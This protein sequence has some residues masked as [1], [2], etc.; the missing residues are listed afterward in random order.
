ML[1]IRCVV[2]TLALQLF[3]MLVHHGDPLIA[4]NP[5]AL[6]PECVEARIV[7]QRLSKEFDGGLGILI[8]LVKVGP[9]FPVVQDSE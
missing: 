5:V 6:L 1:G 4:D 3:N 8:L 7:S 2:V 9:V